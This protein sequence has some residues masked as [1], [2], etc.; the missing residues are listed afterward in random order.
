MISLCYLDIKLEVIILV[1]FI[2]IF[3]NFSNKINVEN[4]SCKTLSN[5]LCTLFYLYLLLNLEMTLP[6]KN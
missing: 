5:I 6:F 1:L 4:I 3:F 2:Q